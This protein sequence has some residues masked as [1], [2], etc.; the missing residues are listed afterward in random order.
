MANVGAEDVKTFLPHGLIFRYAR[1]LLSSVIKI[2]DVE[3]EID[4]EHPV[5]Y[6]VEDGFKVGVLLRLCT[7]KIT[8]M[9]QPFPSLGIVNITCKYIAGMQS[10]ATK[11]CNNAIM[12]EW[13]Q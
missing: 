3:V 5:G 10:I 9:R 2:G 7:S 8:F 4:G 6:G 13:P 12:S 11:N 1:D